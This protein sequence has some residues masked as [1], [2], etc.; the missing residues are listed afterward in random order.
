[1]YT[2]FV[3]SDILINIRLLPRIWIF[4]KVTKFNNFH[5]KF[6]NSPCETVVLD[7]CYDRNSSAV[8]GYYICWNS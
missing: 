8:F 2:Y 7:V 3:L 1:M 6:V 5:V 4:L